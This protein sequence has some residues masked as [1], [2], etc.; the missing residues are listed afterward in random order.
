MPSG[1]CVYREETAQTKHWREKQQQ[2]L[3]LHK[4]YSIEI[5]QNTYKM[6]KAID[7]IDIGVVL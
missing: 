6:H 7:W 5:E 2:P 3:E 1:L 4:Q